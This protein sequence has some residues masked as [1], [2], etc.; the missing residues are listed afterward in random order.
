MAEGDKA[1]KAKKNIRANYKEL[2]SRNKTLS[3]IL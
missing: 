2:Q 1:E 3:F